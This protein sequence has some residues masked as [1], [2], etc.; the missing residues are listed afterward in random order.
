MK[1]QCLTMALFLCISGSTFADNSKEALQVY[2]SKDNGTSRFTVSVGQA[3]PV[4]NM[5]QPMSYVVGEAVDE[6]IDN[7]FI[8]RLQ[9]AGLTS[10]C[11]EYLV[12]NGQLSKNN[13]P[14]SSV[15]GRVFFGF[16]QST[17]SEESKYVLNE[18][19]ETLRSDDSNLILEGN[20]DATGSV[21]YN[22]ALG[23]ERASGV[24][25]YVVDSDVAQTKVT[26]KSN[27]EALPIADNSTSAGRAQNRRVDILVN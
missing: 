6:T 26:V 17:L 10:E 3:I 23:L 19:I 18:V 13:V 21:D 12:K 8:Q 2:C 4:Y 22:L 25:N 24:K 11:A 14:G 16:D 7:V 9:Y 5:H 20:T 1:N 27:G 15:I